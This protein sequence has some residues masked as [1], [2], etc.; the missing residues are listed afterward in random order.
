M[1]LQQYL[2]ESAYDIINKHTTQMKRRDIVK[3]LLSTGKNTFDTID[4]LK[5]WLKD[6]FSLST[7]EASDEVRM[8]R[9][10]MKVLM[11]QK[12]GE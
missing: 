2:N 7:K 9:H 8:M 6:T 3:R 12:L 11:T 5:L 4:A 10:N 1:R